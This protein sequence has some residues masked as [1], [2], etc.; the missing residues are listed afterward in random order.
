M[1]FLL[2]LLIAG[3]EP[4][5]L[6]PTQPMIEEIDPAE[7][8]VGPGDIL[9]FSVQGGVP[10]GLSGSGAEPI[11]HITI[12]PDGY[13]VIPSAGAWPVAGLR[14]FE[15]T[16][17]IEAGFTARYPGLRGMAGLAAIRK[18]RVPLTG[19]VARQGIYDVSGASRLTDLL[20]MAGGIA[21]SGSW[22]LIQIIHSNGDTTE[23]DITEFFLNGCMPSNPVLSLGDRVHV[24]AAVEFVRVEGAV[25][26]SSS[27]ATSFRGSP[28]S[29][30]WTGSSRGMVEY[31]PEETVSV[32]IRRIGGTS[33]WASRDSCH[34]I[35]TLP[36]GRE[37]I[38]RAP[39]D[40]PSIDPELLPGDRVVCP[41]IP[42]VVMVTG[43]VY[44]PGVYPHTA[45]MGA[46][47]YI[48]QAGG[49]L[50]EACESGTEV[51]LPDGNETSAADVQ[52]I[53]P[54]SAIVV[55]RKLLVGWQDPLLIFTSIAS[56][57][58]AW[59]SLN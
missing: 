49:L 5:V 7:Y 9:W 33:T 27:L 55:H 24:P 46:F 30:V 39:L 58:I 38:I 14:L 34:V 56:I 13:A 45:G 21:S 43:Y 42:P 41:G 20:D 35:R 44:S 4:T 28:E 10:A 1:I 36:G 37:E 3:A 11:L 32:L 16:D 15:V 8:V 51:V 12:T 50:R 53:P 25:N 59:K 29:N 18:F 31:I 57:V 40:D 23:V 22:T 19:Q 48:A 17:L 47:Y 54:G 6:V 52:V 2:L 26:M